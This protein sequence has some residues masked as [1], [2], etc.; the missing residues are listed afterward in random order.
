MT[1]QSSFEGL[2]D[3]YKEIRRTDLDLIVKNINGLNKLKKKSSSKTLLIDIQFVLSK[4]NLKDIFRVMDLA[5]NLGAN[6]FI[7]SNIIPQSEENKDNIL[8]SRYENKAIR[9][10]FDKIMLHSLHKGIKVDIPNYELKTIR[11][12][13]FIEY[14]STF[15]CASGDIVPCYRFSHDYTEYILAEKSM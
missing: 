10:L 12:W 9:T 13:N 8:Y 15:I 11:R 6:K 1:S 4:E 3:K 14:S 7:I 2:S 5:S